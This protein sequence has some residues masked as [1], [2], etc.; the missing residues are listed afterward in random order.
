MGALSLDKDQVRQIFRKELMKESAIYQQWRQENLAEG[1]DAE[2]RS[3]ALKML[4]EGMSLEVIA[5]ITGYSIKQI[6]NL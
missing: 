3:I 1:H 5:K 6:Q 2:R 4:A